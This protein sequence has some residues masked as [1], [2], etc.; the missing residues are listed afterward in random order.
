MGKLKVGVG[1]CGTYD[2][3][4][5]GPRA[6]IW[7]LAARPIHAF[8]RLRTERQQHSVSMETHRIVFPVQELFRSSEEVKIILETRLFPTPDTQ[9]TSQDVDS[10]D[11]EPIWDNV[12]KMR[13]L[14]VVSHVDSASGEEQGW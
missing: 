14:V 7:R 4:A 2:V 11:D 10:E 8:R 13:A 5:E 12:Q 1:K 6:R 3:S 9:D